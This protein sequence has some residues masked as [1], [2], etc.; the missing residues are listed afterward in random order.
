MAALR[1]TRDCH[2]SRPVRAAARKISAYPRQQELA[3][4]DSKGQERGR[5]SHRKPEADNV[6]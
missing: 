4:A 5:P 2:S 6:K 1:L 3:R